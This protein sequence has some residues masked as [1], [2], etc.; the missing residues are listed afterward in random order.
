MRVSI[1]EGMA[2]WPSLEWKAY[3]RKDGPVVYR[4]AKGLLNGRLVVEILPAYVM[5][6]DCGPGKDTRPYLLTQFGG[7]GAP[8]KRSKEIK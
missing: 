3:E 7:S 1:E 2:L 5:Q 8:D 4:V 6:G